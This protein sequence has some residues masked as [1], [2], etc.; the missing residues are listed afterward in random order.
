M[1]NR[2][3]MRNVLAIFA[4]ALFCLVV[5]PMQTYLAN[6]DDYLFPAWRFAVEQFVA[7]FAS[8][9]VLVVLLYAA[10][11][12]IADWMC[13]I[14]CAAALCLYVETGPLSFGLGA[15]DGHWPQQLGAFG[16]K[17]WDACVWA[18]IA[19]AAI[20][21]FRW[22]RKF[23]HWIA[24]AVLV[25][26]A[27]SLVDVYRPPENAGIDANGPG[28]LFL[29]DL[30]ERVK[31]SPTRNV[32]FLVLDDMPGIPAAEILANDPSL[33]S[34]FPGFTDFRNN[35]GMH[36]RTKRG[37]PGLFTGKY[38]EPG[39]SKADYLMSSIG[40]NSFLEVYKE[41]GDAIYCMYDVFSYGYTT[42]A[43]K[44]HHRK[45]IL[46]YL[47]AF[48]EPSSGVPYANLADITLYRLAPFAVKEKLLYS[49]L[50]NRHAIEDDDAYSTDEGMLFPRLA[51]KPVSE[52][53]RQVFCKF[54]TIGAHAPYDF[55]DD[56][57]ETMR[58]AVSNVLW[59]AASLMDA[60]K[61]KGIYDNAF[62]VLTTDHGNYL[63]PPVGENHPSAMAFLAVK[64]ARASG[65]LAFSDRPTSHSKIA[66]MMRE[67]CGKELDAKDVE[68]LLYTEKRLFRILDLDNHVKD[69]IL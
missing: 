28:W 60:F 56:T 8:G 54:H 25:L 63:A 48:F 29:D 10:G 61:A 30:V 66:E 55:G 2:I 33:S 47:P 59:H 36:E 3:D 49:I 62:I 57:T 45:H 12:R 40:T 18:A 11:K 9:C 15:I 32:V 68:D 16:R 5:L 41:H 21:T 6:M 22:T 65:P 7:A 35:V 17:V 67:A 43:S 26:G 19:V 1:K 34:H 39:Q 20:G 53:P 64:P 69:W 58:Q 37:V 50:H 31:F 46:G 38:Y 42:D 24:L 44:T 52:D 14:L 23:F 4:I 13:V 27:S 51:A